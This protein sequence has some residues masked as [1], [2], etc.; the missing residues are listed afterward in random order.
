L[1]W[2]VAIRVRHAI[3]AGLS[4]LRG[5][6]GSTPAFLALG[7]G[8]YTVTPSDAAASIWSRPTYPRLD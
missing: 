1:A 2:S 7:T 6:C 5:W 4:V 8:A 3:T